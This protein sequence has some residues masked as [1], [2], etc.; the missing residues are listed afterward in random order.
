M[1]DSYTILNP[2][3]DG[4]VMDEVSNTFGAAP[5]TRKRPKVVLTGA[6]RDE[7][8][9]CPAT[10]PTGTEYGL[11][12]RPIPTQFPGTSISDLQAVTLVPAS[13]ETTVCSYTVPSS[14]TFYFIGYLAQGDVHAVYRL[15]VESTAKLSSRTTVAEPTT[16]IN[17]PNAIFSVDEGDTITLK[18]THY[19]SGIN[20]NF[21]GTIIGYTL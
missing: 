18:V 13:T 7:V 3:E 9:S 19:Q 20:G 21:D 2:G 10:P 14:Q 1:A 12:T 6:E 8:V 11:I 17:F 5:T 15:Y 4:D 16:N